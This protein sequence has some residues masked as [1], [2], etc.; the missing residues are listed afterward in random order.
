MAEISIIIP[1]CLRKQVFKKTIEA[2]ILAI[3]NIEAEI[4]VINDCIEDEILFEHPKVKIYKNTRKGVSSA[5]NFGASLSGSPLLLFIDNDILITEENV[6]KTIQAHLSKDR[7]IVNANWVYPP[8]IILLI[9]K[10]QFGRVLKF[11]KLDSF[12]NRY[13]FHTHGIWY[14]KLFK[15]KFPFAGFYFSIKKYDFMNF[16]MFNED[17]VF[18]EEEKDVSKKLVD[19]KIEYWIDPE[20]IVYH[21]EFDRIISYREWLKRMQ[22]SNAFAM[23]EKEKKQTPLIIKLML[24]FLVKVNYYILDHFPNMPYIDKLF[25]K[26]L[27]LQ[28]VLLKLTA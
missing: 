27:Y 17:I 12:V 24:R 28:T 8:E 3:E 22:I 5:R 10:H 2:A 13:I 4:V 19:N 25:A 7:L 11:W 9:D 16:G 1:T 20:N 14:S 6:L 23:G 21:N 15:A 26:L 18:G